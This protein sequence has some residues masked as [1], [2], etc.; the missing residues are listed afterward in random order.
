MT[1]SP[2]ANYLRTYRKRSGLTQSEVA[3]LLGCKDG[4]KISRYERRHRLPNLR[5][6]FAC[7]S[8]LQV[9]LATIFSSIQREVDR[10]VASRIRQLRLDFEAKRLQGTRT[11]PAHKKLGWLSQ[12]DSRSLHIHE[13][14]Q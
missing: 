13:A 4:T 1:R 14:P 2:I 8:I 12:C 11:K 5:T 10:E 9:P 7:A 3:F 6:A